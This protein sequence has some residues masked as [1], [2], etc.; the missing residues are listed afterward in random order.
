[1]TAP[2][3]ERAFESA[4]ESMLLKGGWV[5]DDRSEWDVDLALFP[6]RV[7]AFL[8]AAQPE[9]WERLAGRL[10]GRLEAL[11]VEQL[12]REL[13]LKGVLGVLRRGFRFQG[14]TLRLAQLIHGR[15]STEAVTRKA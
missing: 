11:V 3:D 15:R 14:C 10:G 2:T 12:V 4:V 7:V 6:A 13:E 1:M 5:E 8:G 9:L